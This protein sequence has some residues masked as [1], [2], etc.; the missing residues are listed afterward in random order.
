MD[1]DDIQAAAFPASHATS[2]HDDPDGIVRPWEAHDWTVEEAQFAAEFL[3]TG[4]IAASYRFACPNAARGLKNVQ[5]TQRGRSMLN[6]PWMRDYIADVQEQ[7]RERMKLTKESVLEELAKL[8][9]ANMSDF[10]VLQADGTPQFDLS[11]LTRDQSAAIQEM[12]ID[13]YTDR[14]DPEVPREVKSVKVKLAPKLGAL[15]ALG[16]HFKLFTDVVETNTTADVAEELRQARAERRR[17]QRE[18][19]QEDQSDE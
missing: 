9:F 12:Q 8:G 4:K 10:V 15:E 1:D 14:G 11:G 2:E 17:R 16:K 18:M 6:A 7:I 3:R 5:L 13:T 19:E